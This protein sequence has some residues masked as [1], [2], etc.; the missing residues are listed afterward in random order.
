M[1]HILLISYLQ[2]TSRFAQ[3]R[4]FLVD[5]VYILILIPICGTHFQIIFNLQAPRALR[6]WFFALAL[7]ILSL[8]N[9]WR[10]L[11]GPIARVYWKHGGFALTLRSV[12]WKTARA[13][14]RAWISH[15]FSSDCNELITGFAREK[16][17]LISTAKNLINKENSRY[18]VLLSLLPFGNHLKKFGLNFNQ[19]FSFLSKLNLIFF[20]CIQHNVYTVV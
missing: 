10:H 2:Y 11:A 1:R 17:N 5:N 8:H 9:L 12:G 13:H 6:W 16:A 14:Q 4:R 19:G 15:L 18:T 20:I 3:Q 7:R